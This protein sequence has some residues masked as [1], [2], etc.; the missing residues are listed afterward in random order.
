[1]GEAHGDTFMLGD[2]GGDAVELSSADRL[3]TSLKDRADAA[4][5]FESTQVPES[6]PITYLR[7]GGGAGGVK[8]GVHCWSRAEGRV[9]IG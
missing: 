4:F 5:P 9:K 7:R 3:F 8:R 2:A 1:M 6:H